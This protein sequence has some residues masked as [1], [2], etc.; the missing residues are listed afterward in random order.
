M[1][2]AKAF[3]RPDIPRARQ[4]AETLIDAGFPVSVLAWDRNIEYTPNQK[5]GEI[6]VHSIRTINL[7]EFSRIGLVVGGFVFQFLVFIQAIREI[8]KAKQR[9]IVHVHDI[10]TLLPGCLLRKLRLASGL[11]YDCR[12]L[13]YALYSEWLHPTLGGIVRV[14]EESS[15]RSVDS[16]ITVNDAIADY[17]HKFGPPVTIVYNCPRLADIPKITKKEARIILG[18]PPDCFI[19]SYIG[20]VR[21][22]CG[23]ELL[24]EVAEQMGDSNVHFLV[25]GDGPLAPKIRQAAEEMGANSN[26]S[27]LPRV[28]RQKALLYT[29]ASDATW[30]IYPESV[31][32]RI[33]SPWKLFESMACGVPV[34]VDSG[35]FQSKIITKFGCGLV[36]KDHAPQMIHQSIVSMSK[37]RVECRRMS[38]AGRKAAEMEFNWENMSRRLTKIYSKSED[39]SQSEVRC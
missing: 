12:E 10:N 1:L 32:A 26:F 38:L 8:R 37:D 9:P 15:L 25:V 31:N 27:A 17:L 3:Q 24:V 39:N 20:M 11:I 7:S 29:L 5:L 23:L 19:V 33:S 35:T 13:T 34:I 16:I 30:A 28:S 2:V 22:G 36:L 4:E 14:L 6:N 21:F 18:L